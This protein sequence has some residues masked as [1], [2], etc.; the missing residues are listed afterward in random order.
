MIHTY[1][2]TG[3]A[4]LSTCHHMYDTII[5]PCCS[6]HLDRVLF[7]GHRNVSGRRAGDLE[8][9]A[10]LANSRCLGR[11]DERERVGA[12]RVALVVSVG[13]HD[14]VGMICMIC[15]IAPTFSC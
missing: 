12:A 5:S 3:R 8:A 4:T 9:V 1:D 10:A 14:L 11:G 13:H 7:A 15:T 6:A 2:I